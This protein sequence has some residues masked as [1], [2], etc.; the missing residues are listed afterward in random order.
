MKNQVVT[1]CLIFI[2]H[3]SYAQK[4]Y[5]YEDKKKLKLFTAML[6]GLNQG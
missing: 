6:T 3:L 1:L 5:V 2:V 4:G